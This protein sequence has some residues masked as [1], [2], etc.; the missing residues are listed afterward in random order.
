MEVDK[1]IALGKH[2]K[3]LYH[4]VETLLHPEPLNVGAKCFRHA[5]L[6]PFGAHVSP[7]FWFSL[8]A[9]SMVFQVCH[10]KSQLW[11]GVAENLRFYQSTQSIKLVNDFPMCLMDRKLGKAP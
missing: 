4:H 8:I 6:K 3:K 5:F 10:A 9:F 2:A 11:R 1:Y 7:H